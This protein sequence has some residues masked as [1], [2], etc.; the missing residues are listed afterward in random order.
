V[1]YV[2]PVENWYLPFVLI[3]LCFFLT[4][5]GASGLFWFLFLNEKLT[6]LR[7]FVDVP[8]PRVKVP[9]DYPII[10][11]ILFQI[12]RWS[13]ESFL[14]APVIL[15]PFRNFSSWLWVLLN[16]HP[17]CL[18]KLCKP[19]THSSHHLFL[20]H[21]TRGDFLTRDHL[22]DYDL[23]FV[24]CEHARGDIAW[25]RKIYW[26]QKVDK[27]HLPLLLLLHFLIMFA[28][29]PRFD[30][31]RCVL[32]RCLNFKNTISIPFY[33]LNWLLDLP[34]L[35]HDSIDLIL[36]FLLA[37]SLLSFFLRSSRGRLL[38]FK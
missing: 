26:S 7:W 38:R 22:G 31:V 3:L 5:E 30:D 16:E 27:L 28:E 15:I 36:E 37:G 1:L 6:P 2:F 21:L 33:A 14:P 17:T 12:F 23:D 24:H 29:F 32:N 34:M 9:M 20:L 4:A 19:I 18:M 11:L 8:I 13:Q 25:N 35:D 10:Q